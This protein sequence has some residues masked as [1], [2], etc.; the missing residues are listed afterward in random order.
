MFDEVWVVA[1]PEETAI[2]RVVEA[3]GFDT[4]SVRDRMRAQMSN[5][6]RLSRADAAIDNSGSLDDLRASVTAAWHRFIAGMDP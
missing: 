2:G 3:R 6:D 5:E 4:D 1:A